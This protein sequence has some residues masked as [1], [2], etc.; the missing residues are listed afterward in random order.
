MGETVLLYSAA[1]ILSACVAALGFKI[2]DES[3]GGVSIT[4]MVA[5]LAKA[6]VPG[7][8][9]IVGTAAMGLNPGLF[10]AYMQVVNGKT[11]VP[12][13]LISWIQ[14][15]LNDNGVYN[16]DSVVFPDYAAG[17]KISF[18]NMPSDTVLRVL[19]QY[20]NTSFLQDLIAHFNLDLSDKCF[21]MATSGNKTVSSI[22]VFSSIPTSTHNIYKISASTVELESYYVVSLSPSSG[23]E[24]SYVNGSYNSQALTMSPPPI[25]VRHYKAGNE[26]WQLSNFGSAT[27]SGNDTGFEAGEN[28]PGKDVVIPG[29]GTEGIT[30]EDIV[31]WLKS[32]V[33]A[34]V[35]SA[36]GIITD[37]IPFVPVGIKN[38][39]ITGSITDA[40]EN[41]I[42]QAQDAAQEGATDTDTVA[43]GE[44]YANTSLAPSKPSGNISAS[45]LYTI[46]NPS[47]AQLNSLAN[48]LWSTDFVDTIKKILQSPMDALISLALFPVT[49][50][51][52]GTHNIALGYIDSGVVAPRVS[53][54]FMTV[55]TTGLVV[56][57]KYNSYLDYAPY[58]K[59]EI[60]LPFIGFCPLN[61]NDIMGKSVDITYNIDLLSGV[62]TAIVHANARSLYS[63][64][65]N[66]AMFLPL[67]AG[68]W[69]RMLTP[70]FGMVG[71]VTS[72]AAGIGGVMGGA[73]LLASTGMAVRGAES[74]GNLDGNSVSRSGGIS[75]NAGIMGDYQPFIV[76]T[77]PINDKPTT[78]DTNIGQTYNKSAQLGTLSGFTVVEEAHIE[79]LSATETEKNEIERLLKEGVIL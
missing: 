64:S 67:S 9:V 79:G 19:S 33:G 12:Q 37:T 68:N 23:I 16:D 61:I 28:V 31:G 65:G 75:G 18:Q 7:F 53:D 72:L 76:V 71:G 73:P 54:Q 59:A 38:P 49:P 63:Y 11:C 5:D 66:M 70:I 43:T 35:A 26:F 74:I 13:N 3:K 55:Q 2:A 27:I 6:S 78:Y 58:T 45:S 30:N 32:A 41:A 34:A 50:H 1:A 36:L 57:H 25:T 40:L 21:I 20:V 22:Q 62:C 29:E 15:W 4:K 8:K 48:F 24:Y 60:F 10:Y 46:W 51:T 14:N 47:Q 39:A 17:D 52:D 77:R 44:K 42:D 69:A 56:P